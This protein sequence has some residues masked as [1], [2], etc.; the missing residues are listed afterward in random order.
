MGR[1]KFTEEL[2][3]KL[4]AMVSVG[5]SVRNAAR[6]VDVRESTV[7][8]AAK[9]NAEFGKRLHNALAQRELLPLKNM[10]TAGAKY[11]R[12]SAWLLERIDR[13]A[14]GRYK[15]DTITEEHLTRF[16]E[17]L[18]KIVREA[19]PNEQ[20]WRAIGRHVDEVLQE[21]SET[22][23]LNLPHPLRKRPPSEESEEPRA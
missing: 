23:D 1:L 2:R 18:V 16:A 19:V 3:T 5:C 21:L 7:R 15:P 4:C 12:A 20:V 17:I 9:K 6:L 14:Y 10:Q 22:G 11:W 8:K 13:T